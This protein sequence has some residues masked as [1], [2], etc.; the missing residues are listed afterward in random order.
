[1]PAELEA[2]DCPGPCA[3]KEKLGP[4]HVER[5]VVAEITYL[6]VFDHIVF[7]IHYGAFFYAAVQGQ[8][9]RTR[10]TQ[11]HVRTF[12]VLQ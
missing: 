6:L 10:G 12:R 9:G 5:S 11:G 3:L 8:Y 7:G 2:V 4:N 1:M